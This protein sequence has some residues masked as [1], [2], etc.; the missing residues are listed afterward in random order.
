MVREAISSF[1][2]LLFPR[3]TRRYFFASVVAD[4][5]RF[6]KTI[7]TIISNLIRHKELYGLQSPCASSNGTRLLFIEDVLPDPRI[8]GGAPRTCQI[9]D[10]LVGQGF[11]ITFIPLIPN[12]ALNPSVARFRVAGVEILFGVTPAE[13][14]VVTSLLKLRKNY[15]TVIIVSRPTNLKRLYATLR[16]YQ[17]NALVVYDAEAVF[18]LRQIMHRKLIGKPLAARTEK[19]LVEQELGL[20]RKADSV[21]AVSDAEANLF[22]G[23]GCPKVAVVGHTVP[24][25]PSKAPFSERSGILFAGPI[26]SSP[27]PNEDAVIFFIT[28]VLPLIRRQMDV[29]FTIVG[30]NSSKRV[31]AYQTDIVKVVGMVDDLTPFYNSNKIFAAPTRYSAGV[32]L[33][34]YDAAA[35]GIPVVATPLLCSQLGWY[36]EKEILCGS[37][38]EEFA[39]ACIRLL[40]D[41]TIWLQIR[42]NALEKV[43]RV[44]DISG[45]SQQLLSAIGSSSE[46]LP[47]KT[48]AKYGRV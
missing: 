26:L 15:Y 34:V 45:F 47:K 46:K 12:K 38:A 23:Y 41:Q 25:R 16:H 22:R 29:G 5:Y 36:P 10:V 13:R 8:G 31:Q 40:S 27:S 14:P 35:N 20:A 6:P 44:C 9:L 3:G 19:R 4:A 11:Q 7:P 48:F 24:I 21:M 43:R 32:P 39:L 17:G 30:P 28:D 42:N 2:E 37:T 33:K 18:A 1:L